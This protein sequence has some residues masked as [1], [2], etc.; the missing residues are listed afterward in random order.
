[1]I[2]SGRSTGAF[3][4]TIAF[5]WEPD[6]DV[7]AMELIRTADSLEDRSQPLLFSRAI[8]IEEHLDHFQD[9]AGPDGEA[10]APWAASYYPVAVVQNIGDILERTLA[11]EY[12][13]VAPGAY[14]ITNDS[15]FFSTAGLPTYWNWMQEGTGT[16]GNWGKVDTQTAEIKARGKQLYMPKGTNWNIGRGQAIPARPFVGMS[17]EAQMKI[18]EVFELWFDETVSGT[19]IRGGRNV[20]AQRTAGGQFTGKQVVF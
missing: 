18:L 4:G 8:A 16:F 6:P 2:Y 14:P 15:V 1:V 7:V 9:Q 5:E 17:I 10:W 19:F 20:L 12:A 13:M 3:G 11:L